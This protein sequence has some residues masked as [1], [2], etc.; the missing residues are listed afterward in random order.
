MSAN[1]SQFEGYQVAGQQLQE[2]NED[3][4]AKSEPITGQLGIQIEQVKLET[5]FENHLKLLYLSPLIEIYPNQIQTLVCKM[6]NT[7]GKTK[8]EGHKR[9]YIRN[10]NK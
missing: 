4:I 1:L 2:V 5:H 9:I 10:E 6:M 7:P 3:G 8:G